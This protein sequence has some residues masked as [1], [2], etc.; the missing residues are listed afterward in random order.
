LTDRFADFVRRLTLR[1][2]DSEFAV[3]DAD[4][5]LRRYDEGSEARFDRTARR[6]VAG[7]ERL[8]H[9]TPF[10]LVELTREL[11]LRRRQVPL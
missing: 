3:R 7:L 9:L 8:L 1:A 5:L 4:L 11:R 10:E 6:V 2:A